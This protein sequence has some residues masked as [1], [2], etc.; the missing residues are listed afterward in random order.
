MGLLSSLV[1][2]VS[3]PAGI[4]LKFLGGVKSA[5]GDAF[6]W[7]TKSVTHMLV[8]V[9][10]VSLLVNGWQLFDRR[11]QLRKAARQHA[12][13]VAAF[14]QEQSA[15]ASLMG[16]FHTVLGAVHSQNA[17]IEHL[18]TT[19]QARQQAAQSALAAATARDAGIMAREGGV[20]AETAQT[21]PQGK[22]CATGPETMA[23]WEQF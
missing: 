4:A 15:F 13:D 17:T 5:I 10:A 1:G 3:P 9:L 12:S 7:V 6:T 23:E 19:S 8:A 11:E 2:L 14:G 20:K 22:T 21:P 18:Y 16:S